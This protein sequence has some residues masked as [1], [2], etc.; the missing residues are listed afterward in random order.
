M[1]EV[2][3]RQLVFQQ[4][5]AEAQQIAAEYTKRNA[6]YMLWSVIVLAAS[7]LATLLFT[8]VSSVV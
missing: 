1:A 2:Y 8:L 3:R 4:Q 5:A 6:T 7:S